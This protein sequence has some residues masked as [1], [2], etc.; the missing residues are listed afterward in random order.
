V[1]NPNE[2]I[3]AIVSI[4]PLLLLQKKGAFLYFEMAAVVA[5]GIHGMYFFGF[6]IVHFL[7]LTAII[8]TAAELISLKTRINFFGVSYRY[9][10]DPQY[11]SS[12][13]RLLGVYPIEVVFAWVIF[14][15]LSFCLALLIVEAFGLPRVIDILLP[16]LILVSVDLILDPV[17]V[18]INKL[19]EW[20]KGGRYFGIPLQNFVGWYMVGLVTSALYFSFPVEHQI[21]FNV[22]YLL[23][24]IFYG[25]FATKSRLL[26]QLNKRMAILGSLPAIIWTLLG[27]VSLVLLFFR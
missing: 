9:L 3:V 12:K 22:L 6:S 4:L 5:I 25:F 13:I 19:W 27:M 7:L 8:S 26:Y 23:P 18:N 20:K 24:I 2:I 21:T 1:I 17:S 14:K 16:P 10:P 15:Y 11:F